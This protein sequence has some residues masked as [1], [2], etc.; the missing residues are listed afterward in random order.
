MM[1]YSITIMLLGIK[2]NMMLRSK[3]NDGEEKGSSGMNRRRMNSNKNK[4]QPQLK[5]N[6]LKCSDLSF[7]FNAPGLA[8]FFPSSSPFDGLGKMVHPPSSM[9]Q[10]AGSSGRGEDRLTPG[11]G[12]VEHWLILQ[13]HKKVIC[14]SHPH[15]VIDSTRF[16]AVH[17]D[18][19]SCTFMLVKEALH[20]V[21]IGSSLN[22]IV[23]FLSD[24]HVGFLAT[25]HCM[26]TH[27]ESTVSIGL[28]VK[29]I[30]NVFLKHCRN[31]LNQMRGASGGDWIFLGDWTGFFLLLLLFFI[32][33]FG[34][35]GLNIFKARWS[36][37][38]KLF[39]FFLVSLPLHSWS[40]PVSF[41]KLFQFHFS[42]KIVF[43]ISI[44]VWCNGVEI[45]VYSRLKIESFSTNENFHSSEQNHSDHHRTQRT[46]TTTV[47]LFLKAAI[48]NMFLRFFFES[49]LEC[50]SF[51]QLYL[52][53]NVHTA[54]NHLPPFFPECSYYPSTTPASPFPEL[55]SGIIWP[56]HKLKTVTRCAT[57]GHPGLLSNSPLL[58]AGTTTPPRVLH[59]KILHGSLEQDPLGQGSSASCHWPVPTGTQCSRTIAQP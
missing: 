37:R 47:P 6:S 4:N 59:I 16:V 27:F 1:L 42:L 3:I 49:F 34:L 32:L 46:L 41:A 31:L 19:C 18:L 14:G 53:Q 58:Q 10:Y 17:P 35:F 39:F 40:S 21:E 56:S 5:S 8:S 52:K 29:Y 15:P 43:I 38:F 30:C 12:E 13:L 11:N 57:S 28:N 26:S 9:P 23:N 45:P 20:H 54:V 48:I 22:I 33:Q 50:I 51:F 7:H 24:S 44:I 25:L 55:L 36:P 2:P